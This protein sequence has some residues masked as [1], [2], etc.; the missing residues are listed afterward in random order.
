[1]AF[2]LQFEV[3]GDVQLSREL[4][5]ISEGVKDFSV[6]LNLISRDFYEGQRATFE[7]EGAAE[8][9]QKWPALSPAYRLWKDQRFP[10]RP[11]LVLRGNLSKAATD[12]KAPGAKHEVSKVQFRAGVDIPV[13]GW[14]LAALH[15][16]GTRR[17]PQRKVIQ[18]SE[19][20]KLRWVQIFRRWYYELVAGTA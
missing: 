10:G 4:R 1:M 12:P 3:G 13:N 17:M 19:P 5:H 2:T 15:Q 9:K 16:F 20:Q 8:G 11:L 18:L 7:A 14:N 6:P